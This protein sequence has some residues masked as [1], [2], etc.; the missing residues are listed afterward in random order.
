MAAGDPLAPMP[1]ERPD[2]GLRRLVVADIHG[3]WP[4]MLALLRRAGALDEH[5][6][7]VPGWWLLHLGDLLYGGR[8]SN[9]D[10]RCLEEG[11]RLFDILL[12]GNHEL[13]HA[14]RSGRFPRFAGQMSLTRAGQALL[15]RAVAAGRFSVA[16]ELDGWLLTHAGLHP[17]FQ[18]ELSWPADAST[19]AVLLQKRFAQRL[20]DGTY[21]PVFDAVAR[22]S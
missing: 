16:A 8:P 18:E 11:L 21:D 3:D 9:D 4:N 15:E 19:C 12:Y 5:N 22:R 1:A 14:Y 20:R 13:P 17:V 6:R 7:R 10:V 2:P